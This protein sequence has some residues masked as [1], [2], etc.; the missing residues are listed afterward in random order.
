MH[1]T[2]DTVYNVLYTL[3]VFV[4]KTVNFPSQSCLFMFF[5]ETRCGNTKDFSLVLSPLSIGEQN[6][7]I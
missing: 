4:L 1:I 7:K 3:C 2:Y 6:V 5:P